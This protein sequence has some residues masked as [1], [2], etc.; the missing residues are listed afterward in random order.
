MSVAIAPLQGQNLSFIKQ[1][2]LDVLK[3]GLVSEELYKNLNEK[4]ER[5]LSERVLEAKTAEMQP[6]LNEIY[7]L[8]KRAVEGYKAN[9]KIQYDLQQKTVQEIVA[10]EDLFKIQIILQVLE[11]AMEPILVEQATLRSSIQN[12][13]KRIVNLLPANTIL[14][15]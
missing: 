5:K 12:F 2:I 15:L 3:P 11:G 13:E 4:I 10:A 8:Y 6:K 9:L 14:I 1:D 7:Q